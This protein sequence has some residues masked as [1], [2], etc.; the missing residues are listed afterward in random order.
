MADFPAAEAAAVEA[1]VGER[2]DAGRFPGHTSFIRSPR[3]LPKKLRNEV[4]S[5]FT[6]LFLRRFVSR[7]LTNDGDF[8]FDF[9]VDGAVISRL[10]GG[11]EIHVDATGHFVSVVIDQIP[12]G[13]IVGF[14]Q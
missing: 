5:D 1:A 4:C 3:I 9:L 8:S 14:I 6:I 11:D 10:P 12:D 7:R 13:S 2:N